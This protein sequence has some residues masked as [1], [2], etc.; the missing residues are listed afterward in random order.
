MNRPTGSRPSPDD[1]GTSDLQPADRRKVRRTRSLLSGTISY[2]DGAKSFFCAVRDFSETG[3]RITVPT[4]ATITDRLFLII[5]RQ[6]KAYDAV[7]MWYDKKEAGLKFE[8]AIPLS[9][10]TANG[11]VRRNKLARS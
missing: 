1:D 9:D 5:A 4:E 2:E 7:V 10:T 8:R 11:L 6:H 3:A